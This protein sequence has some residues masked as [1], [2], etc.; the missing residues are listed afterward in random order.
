MGFAGNRAKLWQRQTE[1]KQRRG[2]AIFY[3]KDITCTRENFIAGCM[4][5]TIHA[6][7]KHPVILGL[8]WVLP[9]TLKLYLQIQFLVLTIW[10][11]WVMHKQASLLSPNTWQDKWNSGS[12]FWTIIHIE[13]SPSDPC[14]SFYS[15]HTYCLYRTNHC[16]MNY[17]SKE[18]KKRHCNG[19]TK[20]HLT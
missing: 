4:T 12:K 15:T 18:T 11:K 7:Q 5:H 6:S 8:W 19:I 1:R 17:F 3:I 13:T 10:S 9:G 20:Q 16:L 2:G 14:T